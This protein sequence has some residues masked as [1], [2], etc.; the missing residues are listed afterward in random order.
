MVR[1][2]GEGQWV[3]L[4]QVMHLSASSFVAQR[5]E[6]LAAFSRQRDLDES[7][8]D[9]WAE[10]RGNGKDSRTNWLAIQRQLLQLERQQAH[11]MNMRRS[12]EVCRIKKGL[13]MSL[14]SISLS[15]KIVTCFNLIILYCRISWVGLTIAW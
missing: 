5:K 8:R 9:K 11:L 4:S 7:A 12:V 2:Q 3:T 13:C 6:I 10:E 15:R 14:V 1:I